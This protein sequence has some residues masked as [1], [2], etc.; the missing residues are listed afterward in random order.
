VRLTFALLLLMTLVEGLANAAIFTPLSAFG[1]AGG[2]AIAV[3]IAFCNVA[4]AFSIG[5]VLLRNWIHR[6]IHRR[7][8]AGVAT[9]AAVAL[10]LFLQFNLAK[11]RAMIEHDAAL[12]TL[13]GLLGQKVVD[14]SLPSGALLVI[15]L[16]FAGIAMADGFCVAGDPYP[17]YSAM[18]RRRVNAR[19][20]FQRRFKQF[21]T[22]ASRLIGTA[23]TEVGAVV[24]EAKRALFAYQALT[25]EFRA[26]VTLYEQNAHQIE[27]ACH[28]VLKDYR[29]KNLFV[30]TAAAPSYFEE[31]A[32]LDWAI[33]RDIGDPG[34]RLAT[35]TA[36][37][38]EMEAEAEDA[39]TRL[40]NLLNR[41]LAD[42]EEDLASIENSAVALFHREE[43]VF[44]QAVGLEL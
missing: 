14:W 6:R 18:A 13:S 12:P 34:E 21:K 17:G 22:G 9:V 32:A 8:M 42:I 29:E 27:N 39:K 25:A 19:Q 10:L 24:R 40:H 20:A 41:H 43:T 2:F 5:M 38:D 36:T 23:Q 44:K 30:R 35:F 15:S 3:L 26:L 1:M 11:F 31:Y 16:G 33:G 37:L 7:I 4:F 28:R